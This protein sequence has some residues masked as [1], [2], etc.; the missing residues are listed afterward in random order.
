MAELFHLALIFP[1][2]PHKVS[3]QKGHESNYQYL[4]SPPA[5]NMC[6][7]FGLIQGYPFHP[8]NMRSASTYVATC[9]LT[10][11]RSGKKIN[12][13]FETEKNPVGMRC[14]DKR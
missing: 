8:P 4:R 3:L 9:L 12:G 14:Q 10:E 11:K 7:G 6:L 5:R 1:R 13:G 2:F